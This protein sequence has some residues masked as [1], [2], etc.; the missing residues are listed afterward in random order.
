MAN[1]DRA[2]PNFQNDQYISDQ[3]QQF[4]PPGDIDNDFGFHMFSAPQLPDWNIDGLAPPDVSTTVTD[5]DY[6]FSSAPDLFDNDDL[7]RSLTDAAGHPATG[8]AEGDHVPAPPTPGMNLQQLEI[9][10]I[11][12]TDV[13]F[14]FYSQANRADR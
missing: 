1:L 7:F 9:P 14:F 2:E 12:R 8:G 6:P 3:N 5:A 13:S 10:P 11:G 4:E